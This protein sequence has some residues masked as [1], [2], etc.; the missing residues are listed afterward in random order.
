MALRPLSLAVLGAAGAVGETVLRALEDQ[1]LPV[2]SLRLLDAGAAVGT[3]LEF[4]GEVV[5]VEE[6]KPGSFRGCEIAFFAATGAAAR[7]WAPH[8]WAEGCAV[9]DGSPAFRLDP[10]VP[11]VVPE[12]NPPAAAGYD[13]RGV[14]ASPGAAAV[15]LALALKPILDA[16]GLERVVVSSCVPASGAG[17]EGVEQLERETRD[18]MNGREPESGPAIP[19]RLAFNLVPQVGSFG[20]GGRTD[21]EVGLREELRRVLALPELRLA[22]TAVQVPVFYGNLHLVNVATRH[23]IGSAAARDLLRKAPGVKLLDAPAERVYPMPMLG[24][25]DDAVLVGR[26]RDDPTQEHGLELVV[27]GDN[28]RKGG[29]TN[30]VQIARLLAGKYLQAG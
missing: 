30:L 8:A 26:V 16:A 9:V 10:E 18:L 11:L 20:E 13:V 24:V 12:V 27:A 19:H 17:R 7:E 15:H 4:H 23:R 2:K 14:V 28:L 22:S 5:E 6:V 25:G 3:A 1:D 21:E 29:A